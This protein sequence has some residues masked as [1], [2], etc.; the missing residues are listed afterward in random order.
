MKFGEFAQ[1]KGA[2][3][4]EQLITAL[5]VAPFQKRK[6]GRILRELGYL[7][8]KSL[9]SLL[10]QYMKT[11]CPYDLKDLKVF[12]RSK[13][14]RF[15]ALL[16]END[17]K[18]TEYIASEFS[19]ILLEK[20]EK[21]HSDD[22]RLY[23]VSENVIK[24][25][26]GKNHLD[27]Q[28]N[29]IFVSSDLSPDEKIQENDPFSKLVANCFKDAVKSNCSDIH[30]EPFEDHYLIRF[31]VHGQLFD[32][33]AISKDHIEPINNK[34]KWILGLDL[35]IVS[36][37]QDSRA[38][39]ATLGC[40]MRVNSIPVS[41]GSEKI[42]VR[43]QYQ[44]QILSL[45]QIGL[46]QQK[47]AILRKNINKPNG[48]IV[49]SGP[50]GSGKTTTLYAL[51]EEM[52]R[53]GKNIST[54]ENPVEKKL[55]RIVQSNI[56]SERDFHSFQRALMRQDPDVILL[57]EIRDPETADLSMKLASTGHL[58]LS[59]VHANGAREVIDRLTNLGVDKFSIEANLNLSVAQRLLR[60]ICPFCKKPSDAGFK[61]N[62]IGCKRC[63][64]GVIGRIA[65]I[66]YLEREDIIHKTKPTTLAKELEKLVKN[67]VI[68]C[69]ELEGMA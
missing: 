12:C 66:E 52:D 31:R 39:F 63:K 51:L 41:C 29:E 40:D 60:K 8:P 7:T 33:K 28:S 25:L 20:L 34:L 53:Q 42:V 57:G 37:P 67:G 14:I 23:L 61:I 48:L 54:L 44:D 36:Q 3:D 38:S 62:K 21:K 6:I 43:I 24:L 26:L 50:T 58:V 46:D 10:L 11:T 1:K 55:E 65:V 9:D 5:K 49:I 35:A 59:T 18:Q 13:I 56:S 64:G 19:D 15:G 45:K 32:W 17:G 4:H 27:K 16:I 47:I 2:I 68:D 30:F 22:V 69:S